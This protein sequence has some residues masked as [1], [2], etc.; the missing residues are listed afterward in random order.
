MPS[1]AATVLA[2]SPCCTWRR[3]A[4]FDVS[5]IDGSA[6]TRRRAIFNVS[7]R[8]SSADGIRGSAENLAILSASALAFR[9]RSIA[10]FWAIL[11]SREWNAPFLALS[12]L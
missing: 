9:I 11:K 10:L 7:S 12:Y 1:S 4:I 5:P 8:Q 6:K 2:L 3:K